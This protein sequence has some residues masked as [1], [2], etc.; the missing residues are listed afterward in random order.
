MMKLAFVFPGQGSQAVGMLAE[1]AAIYPSI[2]ITFSEASDALGFDLW[3]LTQEGPEEKL[4]ITEFTQPALL[5]ASVA[6]WR[7]WLEHNSCL[8]FILAGHSLGEYTALVCAK[9]LELKDAV[10]LVQ[11]RGQFMQAAVAPGVGAM[12]AILG[13]TDEQV[14]T[15]CQQAAENQLVSPANF[16]SPGQVVIAGNTAAVERALEIAKKKG[17]RKVVMLAVSVP[18]HC[19]LMQPA[20]EKLSVAL[21]SITIQTPEIEY[22]N[23]V[24]VAIEKDTALVKKALIAQLVAPVR[25]VETI[26]KMVEKGITHIV[27]CGPGRVLT[28]LNKRINKNLQYMTLNTPD[29][30]TTLLEEIK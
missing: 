11:Q 3:Q 10:K 14:N 22:I 7:V 16:N 6:L 23:N 28:G 8:P 27:E 24:N 2:K 1:M 29:N 26:E 17:A 19:T 30:L 20:A 12:A 25:W 21:N 4:N 18:S 13:L 9:A 15:V 5:T